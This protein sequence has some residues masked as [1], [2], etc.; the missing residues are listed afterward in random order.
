M[1]SSA[2]SSSTDRSEECGCRWGACA[3]HAAIMADPNPRVRPSV[4]GATVQ[5]PIDTFDYFPA[6]DQLVNVQAICGEVSAL[7]PV[8]GQ[9]DLYTVSIDYAP[10]GFVVESKSLKLFL[11]RYRDVG[12]SC[13]D[14]AADI[15]QQLAAQH[16]RRTY[17]TVKV[18]QQSRG[19]IVLVAT[20]EAGT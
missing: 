19:G 9:P 15:A 8:T 1:P 18:E 17:F 16:P 5:H 6:R 7:C 12:I 4:L 13:E 10:M 2:S 14:L 20:A 11:W 3:E